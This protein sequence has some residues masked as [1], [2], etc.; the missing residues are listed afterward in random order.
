MN[1]PYTFASFQ[2]DQFIFFGNFS[3]MYFVFCAC[4]RL[5][6]KKPERERERAIE[7]KWKCLLIFFFVL[8]N[9]RYL[10]LEQENWKIVPE[11]R[12]IYKIDPYFNFFV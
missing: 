1:P 4:K 9:F 3:L 12:I 5:F 2:T 10:H 7:R 11:L 6:E 8:S